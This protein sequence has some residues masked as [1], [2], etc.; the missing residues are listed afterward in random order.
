MI[1][2]LYPANERRR[3]KVTPPPIG[4]TQA[5][6]QPYHMA[7]ENLVSISSGSGMVPNWRL[8]VSILTFG[9]LKLFRNNRQEN[10]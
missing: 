5:Y 3:Y 10:S 2:G 4:K 7:S 1:L 6:N 8:S 9:R